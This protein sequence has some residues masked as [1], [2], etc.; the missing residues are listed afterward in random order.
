MDSRESGMLRLPHCRI[1]VPREIRRLANQELGTTT[2][3]IAGGP[4]ERGGY[5]S[6]DIRSS[7]ES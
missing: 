6:L 4:G 5:P 1:S 7:G 2:S 3:V